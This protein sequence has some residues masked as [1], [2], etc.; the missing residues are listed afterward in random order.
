[1]IDIIC[2]FVQYLLLLCEFEAIMMTILQIMRI[3]M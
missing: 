2:T 3:F 1:M